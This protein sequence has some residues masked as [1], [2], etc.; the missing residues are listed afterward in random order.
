MA[1]FHQSG[2]AVPAWWLVE[3][4]NPSIFSFWNLSCFTGG[5]GPRPG[6]W[7]CLTHWW[8]MLTSPFGVC[9]VCL[10]GQ[11]NSLTH[12][13]WAWRAVI[14][15]VYGPHTN[16]RGI[17]YGMFNWGYV[18]ICFVWVNIR[19]QHNLVFSKSRDGLFIFRLC[20]L[21]HCLNATSISFSRNW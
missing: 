19:T 15:R 16:C 21:F 13:L 10:V 8:T 9:D 12:R 11:G 5:D 18:G 2:G 3:T 6:R 17:Y 1:G 14:G 20:P 7:V 4:H